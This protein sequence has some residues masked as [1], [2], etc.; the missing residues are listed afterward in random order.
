MGFI[1]RFVAWSLRQRLFVLLCAAALIATGVIAY[2]RA[3][4]RG[5]SRPDE[6]PGRGRH[7][8]ARPG[9]HRGRAARVLP[10]RD[11]ADG[12]AR[13]GGGPLHLEGRPL[14]RQHHLR[15]CGA[16]VLRA[17]AGQRA[18]AGGAEPH[19]R[20]ARPDARPGR[21]GVR[22]DLPVPDRRRRR[23]R[24]DEEDAARL[25][26]PHADAL[27]ARRERD[28]LVGRRDAAVPGA[29]RSAAARPLRP[30]AAPGVRG[31]R[32]QQ[33]HLRRRLHRA[34][35]RALYRA[36]R[37]PRPDRRRPQEHRRLG[38][39]GHADLHPRR[40]R[41]GDRRHAAPGRR[42]ARRQGRER[43]RHDH[44]AEGR[45][46][47]GR[48]RPREGAP[49]RHLEVAAGRPVDQAVL[50]PDRGHRPHVAHRHEEP[51]RGLAA[52]RRR[53]VRVPGRRARG[54]AGGGRH[55]DVDA[56][57]V[58]RHALLRRLGEPDVA[59]RHRLRP[60]RRRRRRDDGELRPAARRLPAGARRRHEGVAARAVHVGGHRG[61]AADPVRRADHRRRLPA[62]LHARGA[63]GEDVPADGHHRV[64][65]HPRVA[66]A[67][68]DR[69]ARRRVVPAQAGRRRARG[70]VVRAPE[71]LLR[72][73]PRACR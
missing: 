27:G 6:Q 55:P 17:A 16:G 40:R 37:R 63:R 11:R 19:P 52:G 15:R 5:V 62:H 13:R 48:R 73:S 30:D 64:L 3:A 31:A 22:R 26:H 9:R 8:R 43:R 54:A 35:E 2:P 46:R 47:E 25:G 61:R 49:G 34:P 69:G 32:R 68:A 44:H 50:R 51:H 39:G 45:E 60:H 41:G 42:D 29:G 72:A 36:R 24:D 58:H 70:A 66:A 10:H 4:D 59:R 20:R 65:G 71:A 67:V 18:D 57:R 28:Q 12:R 56:G 1:E 7:R 23:R 33:R 14:D 53:A 38:G 21:D